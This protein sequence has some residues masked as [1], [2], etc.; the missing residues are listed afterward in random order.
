MF[1][2][3]RNWRRRKLGKR[4][5]PVEWETH[6]AHLPFYRRLDPELGARFR[7]MLKIFVWEKHFFGAGGFEVTDR[8]KVIISAAAVRLV[9]HLSLDYYDRLTEIVVYPGAFRRPGDDDDGSVLLGEAHDW[10][11]VVLSWP[12]V[13][14]GLANPCDGHDTAAH[15]FAHVLDRAAGRFNGTP[16]LRATADY[17]V[18]AEVMNEHFQNLREGDLLESSVMREY[19]A[20]NEAEFFA[21]ATESFF[22][23]P[24]VMRERT[25][26][27]YAELSRFYGFD[28]AER[29]ICGNP[30]R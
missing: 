10:G 12:A 20:K 5:F 28:P 27:L 13:V 18:W 15:E 21:V 6:L 7:E 25:P 11:T 1:G 22:E 19:G 23:R 29:P 2:V 8:H 26:E 4:P 14:H 9:L 16:E 17:A 24:V 3:L 30:H